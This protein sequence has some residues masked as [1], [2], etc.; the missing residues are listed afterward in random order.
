MAGE[1]RKDYQRLSDEVDRLK[2]AQEARLVEQELLNAMESELI[3][4]STLLH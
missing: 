4:R 1:W 3:E 2:Q